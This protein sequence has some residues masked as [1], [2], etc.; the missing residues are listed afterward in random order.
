M[1]MKQGLVRAERWA[2]VGKGTVRRPRLASIGWALV[3]LV[4]VVPSR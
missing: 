1:P 3:W 4:T 2:V